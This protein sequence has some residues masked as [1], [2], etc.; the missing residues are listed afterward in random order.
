M[1]DI[2]LG[3]AGRATGGSR[4]RPKPPRPERGEQYDRETAH[5]GGAP[6]GAAAGRAYPFESHYAA[7]EGASLHYADQGSGPPVL[8][9]HGNPTWSVLYR[10]L[11][12]GL[13]GQYR[14]VAVDLAGFG[15]SVPPPDF[16][17]KPED[18]AGLAAGLLDRLDLRTRPSSRTT[19]AGRSGSAQR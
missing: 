18:Q 8:M 3:D 12:D 7:V 10:G 9:V 15:L 11:I 13:R 16:S 17:F 19:G 5:R 2:G 1:T 14:C 6:I 4:R